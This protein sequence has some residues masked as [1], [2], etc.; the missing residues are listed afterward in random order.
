MN[1]ASQRVAYGESLVRMGR[2]DERIVVLEAD[3]GKSTM[4]A[5]FEKEIHERFFEMGIAEANMAG[6]S[7]GLA[8]GGHIPFMATFAVF[9]TGRCY[10]Q[11]R[12]GICIPALNVKIC[13]SSAGLSDYGDGSTH[14]AIEDIAT[15]RVLPNMQVFS[16]V[17]AVQTRQIMKYMASHEG[18]MYIRIN[19]NDLPVYCKENDEFVPGHI[20]LMREGKDAVV[21]ATGV[22]VSLA[23][24]AA[25]QLEK[26]GISLKVI[27]VP[28]IKPL[29]GKAVCEAI[30]GIHVIGTAEEHSVVGGLGSAILEQLAAIEHAP[31]RLIGVMDQFGTSAENYEVLLQKYG[32][33]AERI[34]DEIRSAIG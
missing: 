19:R 32:L 26:E 31:I 3:L 28:S 14:Q 25:A 21:F 9:A 33:T 13:G 10:D 30:R 34:A 20:Q 16:P 12:T 7:A 15:M 23:L 11:L 8:L 1:A 29:D 6:V 27:N 18:P 22:M 4:G 17:D 5:M 24:N 2:M